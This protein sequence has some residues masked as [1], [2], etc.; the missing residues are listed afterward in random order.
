[1]VLFITARPVVPK[2]TNEESGFHKSQSGQVYDTLDILPEYFF[3]SIPRFDGILKDNMDNIN[4]WLYVMKT[5]EPLE[6]PRAP[7]M[8]QAIERL[9]FINMT[10]EDQTEYIRHGKERVTRELVQETA[11]AESEARGKVE[12]R[13]ERDIE[14]AKKLLS[15]NV[16]P[17]SIAQITDLP[18]SEVIAL[19]EAIAL[20]EVT[21]LPEDT[22]LKKKEH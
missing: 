21:A 3:V 4:E 18:L 19:F 13:A 17:E 20:P 14:I 1:M 22:S 12:G 8:A 11:N 2:L 15:Q 7:F 10:P 5:G 6:N 16:N 9:R